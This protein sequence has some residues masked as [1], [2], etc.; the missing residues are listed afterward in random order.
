MTVSD[1]TLHNKITQTYIDNEVLVKCDYTKLIQSFELCEIPPNVLKIQA[2]L[3][4]T[5]AVCKEIVWL[6]PL[7]PIPKLARQ[8]FPLAILEPTVGLNACRLLRC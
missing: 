2:D 6:L 7:L 8:E 5:Y 4:L 3:Q 1:F